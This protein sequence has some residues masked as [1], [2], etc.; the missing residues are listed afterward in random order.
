MKPSEQITRTIPEHAFRSIGLPDAELMLVKSELH[1]AIKAAIQRNGWNQKQA[2]ERLG[3]G[4]PDISKIM[5]DRFSQH[6]VERL[7]KA[8]LD[9]GLTVSFG[10]AAPGSKREAGRIALV[11]RAPSAASS[12]KASATRASRRPARKSGARAH[13]PAAATYAAAAD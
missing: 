2:G 5:N 8:A 4:Q 11:E 12:R 3:W 10:V 9:L 13:A 6:S 7:I 1:S